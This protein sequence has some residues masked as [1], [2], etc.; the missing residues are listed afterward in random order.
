MS[1]EWGA[2]SEEQGKRKWEARIDV[3]IPKIKDFQ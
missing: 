3:K 1:L 2:R